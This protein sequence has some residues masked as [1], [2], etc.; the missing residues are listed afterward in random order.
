VKYLSVSV[1][2]KGKVVPMHAMK[3]Y[4]GNGSVTPHILNIG[5]RQ[6]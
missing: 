5:A 6:G 3:V 2:S 1:Q 4:M